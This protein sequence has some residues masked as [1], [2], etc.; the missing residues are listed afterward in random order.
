VPAPREPVVGNVFAAAISDLEARRA[1]IDAAI[2][3]LRALA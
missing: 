2:E 1:K 3:T